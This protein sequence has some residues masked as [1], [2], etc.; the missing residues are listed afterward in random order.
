MLPALSKTCRLVGC[1]VRL[2]RKFMWDRHTVCTNHRDQD[3]N[4]T[5]CSEC[6]DWTP[7]Q[8]TEY[9]YHMRSLER[10]RLAK[11]RARE[12]EDSSSERAT[13]GSLGD[14]SVIIKPQKKT[15]RSP[16][17]AD[18]SQVKSTRSSVSSICS[19]PPADP[20]VPRSD[21][22]ILSD[23]LDNMSESVEGME[24]RISKNVV[25]ECR[26]MIQDLFSFNPS[27]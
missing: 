21:F 16:K 4:L 2:S 17:T 1:S 5:C 6:A 15:S 13:L 3:C 24:E 18:S 23:R 7:A 8:R 25:S 20:G 9:S 27:L 19:S 11:Q 10:K 22:N 14:G 26:M 12:R